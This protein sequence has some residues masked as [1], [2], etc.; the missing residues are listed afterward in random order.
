MGSKDD[1]ELLKVIEDDSDNIV[2][3]ASNNIMNR[4]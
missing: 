2:K 3:F 4:P 1:P